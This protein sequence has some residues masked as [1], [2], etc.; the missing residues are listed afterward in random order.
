M[1]FSCLRSG[2]PN[3]G[4]GPLPAA[5]V[6]GGSMR[7]AG[8]TGRES[9]KANMTANACDITHSAGLGLAAV[10][11]RAQA[12][13]IDFV[14]DL[15]RAGR[16]GTVRIERAET[17]A[18]SALCTLISARIEVGT[19]PYPASEPTVFMIFRDAQRQGLTA[20]TL[21]SPGA[22]NRI[23]QVGRS[24]IYRSRAV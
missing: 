7:A 18:S 10:A 24:P 1:M 23:S 4:T 15:S 16:D 2:A 14:I 11:R 19:V 21:S 20:D 12:R 3:V 17:D 22:P 9:L 6:S 5:G 8:L 13:M